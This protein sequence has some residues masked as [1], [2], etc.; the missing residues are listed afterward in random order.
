MVAPRRAGAGR[1]FRAVRAARRSPGGQGRGCCGRAVHAVDA[2]RLFDRRSRARRPALVPAL[3]RQGSRVRQRHDRA[4]ERRRLRCAAADC[5]PRCA[6][7]ALPRLSC[8]TFRI[9]ARTGKPDASGAPAA[10]LGVGRGNARSPDDHGQPRAA[11]RFRRGPRRPDGLG[12]AQLRCER[13]VEGCRVGPLAPW[14]RRSRSQ[15]CRGSSARDA[16]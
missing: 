8:R 3:Y 6:G 7:H 1:P 14:P 13:D 12:R 5:R 15:G 10:R 4:G 11:A 2:E 9:A 16:G